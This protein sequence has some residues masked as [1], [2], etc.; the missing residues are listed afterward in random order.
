MIPPKGDENIL[1]SLTAL[2]LFVTHLIMIPP[3]GDENRNF[4]GLSAMSDMR[5]DNDSPER[6][7]EHCQNG[8]SRLG[9]RF[10]NESPERGR[11]HKRNFIFSFID[12]I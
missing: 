3:K 4:T 10:D 9:Q 1:V 12:P 8:I 7:R 2:L 5:F 6:G 11:E